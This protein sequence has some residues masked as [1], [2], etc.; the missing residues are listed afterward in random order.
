LVDGHNL[1]GVMPGLSLSDP[2]DEARLT[3]LLQRFCNRR[4]QRVTVYFDRRAPGA[5]QPAASGC[6]TAHFVTAP[7]TA[8]AAIRRHLLRLGG[9]S[10][11]WTVVS[12]DL[13]VIEAARRAGARSVPSREFSAL[14]RRAVSPPAAEKPE[15][16]PTPQEI[17][18]LERALRR[19]GRR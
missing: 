16:P 17:R 1:I 4:R 19:R 8:D 3:S 11:N 9:E 14:L 5:P 15:A 10:H 6:V 7:D 2:D 18:D 13:E 12:S